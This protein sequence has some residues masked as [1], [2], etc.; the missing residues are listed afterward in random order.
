MNARRIIMGLIVVFAL[1]QLVPVNRTNPAEPDP[2]VFKNPQAEAIAKRACYA[3]HS[4]TNTW[5]WYSYIAPV[6][7]IY[8]D[9]VNE[10]RSELNFS[11]IAGTMA[12][13]GGG[14]GFFAR[15]YADED[16][17][18]GNGNAGAGGA[19]GVAAE[20]VDE[21]AESIQ[22][23]SMPPAYYYIMHKNDATL[24]AA[25]TQILLDGIR[26]ALAGR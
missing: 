24:T 21:V 8:V 17:D 4:N 2:I 7:W 5:D 6:S 26:E 11:D 22:E 13:E 10:G 18:E 9:H 1:I 14:E 20:I 12:G 23:G 15:A 3:C 16:G 25:D 19:G